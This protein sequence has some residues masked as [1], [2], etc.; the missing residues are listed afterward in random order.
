MALR[1][2]RIQ[3]DRP[4]VAT[5]KSLST[6]ETASIQLVINQAASAEQAGETVG[7]IQQTARMFLKTTIETAGAVPTDPHVQQAV[8]QRT[9]FLTLF[10]QSQAAQGIR[11]LAMHVKTQA[12]TYTARESFFARLRSRATLVAEDAV[13]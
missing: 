1:S 12:S 6:L 8:V 10:P 3:N 4:E 9:P 2:S 13:A 7:R 5:I 11:S